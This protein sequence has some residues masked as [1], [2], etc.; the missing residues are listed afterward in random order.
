M[1]TIIPIQN[2]T[3]GPL[4]THIKVWSVN[5]DLETRCDFNWILF[6]ELSQIVNSGMLSCE[7]DNY[8]L[9]NGDNMFPY[10]YVTEHLNIELIN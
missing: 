4:C 1:K 5:D 9:W 3:N 8:N 6:D 10:T 2:T 7:E